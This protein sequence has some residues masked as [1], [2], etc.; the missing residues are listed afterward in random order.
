[1]VEQQVRLNYA[2]THQRPPPAKIYPSPPT[3]HH[4]PKYI[5]HHPPQSK[6]GPPPSQ[7]QCISIYNL[8]LRLFL[9]VYFSFKNTIVLYV[10]L[11]NK[12]LIS[13][14]FKF[15]ISTTF[16]ICKIILKAFNVKIFIFVCFIHKRVMHT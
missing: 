12:V 6:N 3:T 16:Y 15:K 2:T 8:L 1:M 5:R 14:F 13:S 11:C 9:T 10:T 4:Q 7:N